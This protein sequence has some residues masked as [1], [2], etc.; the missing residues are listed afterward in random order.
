MRQLSTPPLLTHPCSDCW[1]VSS[2]RCLALAL[3]SLIALCI[4]PTT[5]PFPFPIQ[6]RATPLSQAAAILEAIFLGFPVFVGVR[7]SKGS[8]G[9]NKAFP[10]S[11]HLKFYNKFVTK[12]DL[13][14]INDKNEKKLK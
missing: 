10:L 12:I 13:C 3:Q 2:S 14:A 9:R 1:A 4:H 8:G 11:L 5:F 6:Q 7:R